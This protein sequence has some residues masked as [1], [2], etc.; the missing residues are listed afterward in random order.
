M[1]EKFPLAKEWNYFAA[2]PPFFNAQNDLFSCARTVIYI[3]KKKHVFLSVCP[4]VRPSTFY[5]FCYFSKNIIVTKN[6]FV[7]IGFKNCRE[8]N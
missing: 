8:L 1:H 5:F 2:I 6:F 7:E 3:I 4:S